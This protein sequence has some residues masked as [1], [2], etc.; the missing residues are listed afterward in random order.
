MYRRLQPQETTR[1]SIA[2]KKP[3]G[4]FLRLKN[5]TWYPAAEAAGTLNSI[6][7]LKV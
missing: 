7:Q 6:L 5:Q 3:N 2:E 4:I 1:A